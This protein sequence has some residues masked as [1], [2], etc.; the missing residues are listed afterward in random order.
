MLRCFSTF[1]YCLCSKIYQ[2]RVTDHRIG[3]SLMNLTSIME[4]NGLQGFI[5]ALRR[6]HEETLMETL[7]EEP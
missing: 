1:T 2:D 3:L 5:D 7:L 6:D 4:G